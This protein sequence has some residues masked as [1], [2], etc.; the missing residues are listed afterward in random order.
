M[1]L[2]S[3]IILVERGHFYFYIPKRVLFKKYLR[4]FCTDS[5]IPHNNEKSFSNF[6]S[7][8]VVPDLKYLKINE[9][10]VDA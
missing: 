8:N 2:S 9:K 1:K 10:K 6:Q 3:A 4:E 5:S 7:V